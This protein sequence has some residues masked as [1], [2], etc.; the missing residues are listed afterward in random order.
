MA[1]PSD[2]K[3][4]SRT[5]SC[6]RFLQFPL[7]AAALLT[8]GAGCDAEP[9]P[10]EALDGGYRVLSDPADPTILRVS[11]TLDRADVHERTAYVRGTEWG[12]TSQVEAPRCGDQL[13]APLGSGS[14]TVPGGC[15]VLEWTIR[16]QE[17]RPNTANASRQAT[18]YFPDGRWWLLSE[19]TSL[20]RTDPEPAGGDLP[21]RIEGLGE[22]AI[23]IGAV[24]LEEGGWR[25]PPPGSAPEFFVFGEPEVRGHEMGGFRITYVLD[26]PGPWDRLPLGEGHEGALQYLATVFPVPPDLPEAHRHLL[27]IWLGI[28]EALGEAGGAAGSRSF[29]A[30]YVD[31]NDQDLELNA[32]RTLLILAHEQ[33]HQL[34]D[35]ALL[36]GPPLPTWVGESLAHYY[37][38]EALARTS[39]PES[40]IALVADFFI[41]PA[42]PV[43]AGLMELGRRHGEG[44]P[45]AYP[46]FY[47]QGAT[48]WSEV[49]RQLSE[50]DPRGPG[51]D[52]LIP[53]L[54][55][56]LEGGPGLP[57]DFTRLL[58]ERGGPA[59]DDILA[60]YVGR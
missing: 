58:R 14:W 50:A 29:I 27:V 56:T 34:I 48:F 26:D 37:G 16:V 8:V 44:D 40:V 6:L 30:N 25:L 22:R 32:A 31:G 42:R 19:P 59:M 49:D 45:T 55:A 53:T 24:V 1:L 4:H 36:G 28:D 10:E 7:V 38:I 39:L 52:G 47:L 41:D 57:A 35:L 21:L 11:L 33:V 46:M 51:L 2:P 12:L 54:L 17:A 5:R 3:M 18:W 23:Q 60:R 43:E 9:S 15:Q 20:L 13:L